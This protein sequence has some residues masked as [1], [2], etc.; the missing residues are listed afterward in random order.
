MDKC[1]KIIKAISGMN[2]KFLQ[3]MLIEA[4]KAIDGTIIGTLDNTSRVVEA[5]VPH[6]FLAIRTAI[7]KLAKTFNAVTIAPTKYD[8]RRLCQYPCQTPA[9]ANAWFNVPLETA[10]AI[11]RTMKREGTMIKTKNTNVVTESLNAL[12][13]KSLSFLSADGQTPFIGILNLGP[14]SL[15]PR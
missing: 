10:F 13:L 9:P 3:K 7:G 14:S 12:T 1:A 11:G 5:A 2:A 4:P 15:I 8:N 6:R